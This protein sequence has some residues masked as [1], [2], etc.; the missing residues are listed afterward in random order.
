MQIEIKRSQDAQNMMSH[1]VMDVL[2][3]Y[4][5]HH[6]LMNTNLLAIR[7]IIQVTKRV[8][9]DL[10][11]LIRIKRLDALNLERRHAGVLLW[12]EYFSEKFIYF[13]N[14]IFALIKHIIMSK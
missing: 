13:L 5:M 6:A 14:L 4:S 10:D 11:I 2:K 1:A 12:I 9:V 7:V 8:A 3:I